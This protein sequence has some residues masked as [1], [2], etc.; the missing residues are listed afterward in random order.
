MESLFIYLTL[1]A[2]FVVQG[3]ILQTV[4]IEIFLLNVTH[5]DIMTVSVNV[6]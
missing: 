2:D 1:M 4:L 3:H 5:I 6:S